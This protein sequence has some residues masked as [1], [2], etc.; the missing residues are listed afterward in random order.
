MR[1]RRK[2][3]SGNRPRS[4]TELSLKSRRSGTMVLSRRPGRY[5]VS[6]YVNRNGAQIDDYPR[7][8]PLRWRRVS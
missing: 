1:Y 7:R 8:F 3:P 6:G 2:N 4:R 5:R